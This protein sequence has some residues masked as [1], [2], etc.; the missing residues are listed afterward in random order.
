MREGANAA[1]DLEG[2]VLS[3]GWKVL[4]KIEKKKIQTGAFF[5]VLYNV[6]KNGEICFMK[7]FDFSKFSDLGVNRKRIEQIRSK[8]KAINK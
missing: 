1:H 7:A 2:R 3:S 6:R 5:S 8:F 4:K